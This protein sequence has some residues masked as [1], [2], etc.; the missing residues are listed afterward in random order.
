MG[1]AMSEAAT[2]YGEA[3]SVPLA[4]RIGV[5]S[6]PVVAGVIGQSKFAYDVWG[7]TVNVASRLETAGV[8]GEVQVSETTVAL[9]GDGFEIVPRGAIEL[10]GKGAVPAF[11]VRVGAA[12][13]ASYARPTV[14]AAAEPTSG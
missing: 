8:P 2:S 6:G 9:L 3:N 4:L 7:D 12:T 11:L 5:H 13:G 1:L 14:A 10:K